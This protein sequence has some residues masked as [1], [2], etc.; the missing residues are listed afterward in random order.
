MVEDGKSEDNASATNGESLRLDIEE[1]ELQLSAIGDPSGASMLQVKSLMQERA[2]Q[3]KLQLQEVLAQQKAEK[4]RSPFDKLQRNKWALQKCDK[5]HVRAAE[6]L[7]EAN[8]ALR[9]AEENAAEA[10]AALQAA[11]AQGDRL[12]EEAVLLR[13]EPSR[14]TADTARFYLR[15]GRAR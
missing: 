13:K 1:L 11:K 2:Q 15:G 6:R 12:R 5:R 9:E 4:E 7:E 3:L 8:K 10:T 14:R